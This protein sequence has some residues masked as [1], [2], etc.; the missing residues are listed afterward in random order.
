MS[1]VKSKSKNCFCGKCGS[2]FGENRDRATVGGVA[3]WENCR[4]KRGREFG[5]VLLRSDRGLN[6]CQFYSRGMQK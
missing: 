3:K 5:S 4:K 2:E 6:H 1:D